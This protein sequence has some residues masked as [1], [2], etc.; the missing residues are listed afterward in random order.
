VL[1]NQGE[2]KDTYKVSVEPLE[3]PATDEH[4]RDTGDMPEGWTATLTVVSINGFEDRGRADEKVTVTGGPYD[5][6]EAGTVDVRLSPDGIAELLLTVTAPENGF[7]G[8]NVTLLVM[9]LSGNMEDHYPMEDDD[10]RPVAY[11][12]VALGTSVSSVD[13]WPDGDR[14]VT[15]RYEAGEFCLPSARF[16]VKVTNL[17]DV[18][19][20]IDLSADVEPGVGWNHSLAS[21]VIR[22][23]PRE[24]VNVT[25]EVWYDCAE[26]ETQG[27]HGD[28]PD[29]TVR[30]SVT[31]RDGSMASVEMVVILSVVDKKN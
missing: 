4:Q 10:G 26:A 12:A 2:T 20:T 3:R 29:G 23:G 15:L 1:K 14:E 8:E 24:V 25:L 7:I 5:P 22:L 18:P 17:A 28:P 30:F 19:N 6:K 27:V 11:R 13:V 31:S 9:A 16:V 21:P